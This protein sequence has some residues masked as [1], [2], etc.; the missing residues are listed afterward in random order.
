M[1]SDAWRRR[2]ARRLALARPQLYLSVVTTY[3]RVATSILYLS[4]RRRRRRRRRSAAAAAAFQPPPP[5][6]PS[7]SPSPS[8]CNS[9]A[10]NRSRSS[11]SSDVRRSAPAA[12]TPR[13][14]PST[15]HPQDPRS[16]SRRRRRRS[17]S[18]PRRGRPGP[19]PGASRR[20]GRRRARTSRTRG[21]RTGR[22]RRRAPGT[23]RTTRRVSYFH[24]A[25]TTRRVSYFHRARV[26]PIDD[27][28]AN[29][30]CATRR[31]D[32]A[33]RDGGDRGRIARTLLRAVCVC[34]NSTPRFTRRPLSL[35]RRDATLA[36][37]WARRVQ[38]RSAATSEE[39]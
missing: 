20:R 7:R 32:D 22:P 15:W 36:A 21:R 13:T 28:R 38:N 5:P 19:T 30:R 17:R 1:A 26:G 23:L 25:R 12:P 10:R 3:A 14:S 16:A 37:K 9:S 24:R 29:E 34:W 31:G 27:E 35:R 6:S 11:P 39:T 8:P 18:R 33:R 4:R 2:A